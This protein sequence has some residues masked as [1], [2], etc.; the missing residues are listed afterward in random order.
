MT[1]EYPQMVVEEIDIKLEYPQPL[2][3][4]I[5][6]ALSFENFSHSPLELFCC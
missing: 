5:F 2:S 4:D 6:D 3:K 1:L